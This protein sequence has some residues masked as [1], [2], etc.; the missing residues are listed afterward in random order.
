LGKDLGDKVA[1][2]ASVEG[3][4]CVA[5]AG[6]VAERAA[7]LFGAA[8]ALREATGSQLPTTDRA[9]Q[10]A[11]LAAARSRV[12]EGVWIAAWEE[13]RFTAFEEALDYA[14]LE[15]EV[16]TPLAPAQEEPSAGQ[17]PVALT[18]REDEVAAMVAQDMPNRQIASEL[19]L[20]ERT[21]ENH[22]SK[23]LRKLGLTSRAQI[24]AW[25]AKQALLA[26]EPD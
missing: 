26:P 17:A 14:L 6:R 18:A 8:E 25:T 19:H 3:M 22:I 9:V 1:G 15:G 7:R 2:S 24:A 12:G 10:E 20:S 11:Y 21:V 23:I 13:G 5:G 16:P 4:A